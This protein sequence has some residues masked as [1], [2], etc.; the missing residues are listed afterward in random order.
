MPNGKMVEEILDG[1]DRRRK[2]RGSDKAWRGIVGGMI[3]VVIL[4]ILAYGLNEVTNNSKEIGRMEAVQRNVLKTLSKVDEALDALARQSKQTY[5]LVKDIDTREQVSRA[6]IIENQKDIE[7]AMI[8]CDKETD[9]LKGR[10][11]AL[12]G[13]K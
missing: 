7:K 9:S 1:M 2:T 6:A 13:K 8:D 12:E 4:P 11:R 10:I 3:V 5:E